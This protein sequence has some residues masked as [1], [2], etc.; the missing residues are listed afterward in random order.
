MSVKLREL[1]SK[2][3]AFLWSEDYQ[4]EFEQVKSLLTVTHF[5]PALPVTM[6]T[7]A[8]HLHG[9]GFAMGH[10]ADGQFKLVTCGSKALTPT[11]QRYATIELEC[12][13]VHFAITKCSFYSKGLPHFTVATDHK[14]MEGIFKK[15]LFEVQNPRLQRMREKLLPYTFTVKRV[16]GKGHHIA[17]ALSRAPLFAP[18]N[19]DDMYSDTARTCL[20][21]A[22]SN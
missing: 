22:E 2:K 16:A 8:S 20:V 1:T 13:A 19:L 7:D 3:N 17:D 6:L 10:Y 14:P 5:N 12:L 4:K 15:D 21:S 9:L 18:A 11:Q